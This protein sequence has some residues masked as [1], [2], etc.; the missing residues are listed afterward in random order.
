KDLPTP[1][2]FTTEENQ[3]GQSNEENS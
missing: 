3:I 1:K 2:D